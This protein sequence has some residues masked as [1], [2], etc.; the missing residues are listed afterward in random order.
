VGSEH[1][2]LHFPQVDCRLKIVDEGVLALNAPVCQFA[3]LLRVKSFPGLSVQVLVESHHENRVA[4]INEG[5]ADIAVVLQVDWQVEEVV[6]TLVLGV[7]TLQQHLL[8]VLVRNVLDHYR[9]AQVVSLHDLLQV[10][11]E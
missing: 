11:P 8:G 10:Q 6:A 4:H 1:S 2:G 3:D 9:R 7:N 5:V